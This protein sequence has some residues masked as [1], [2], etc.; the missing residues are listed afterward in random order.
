VILGMQA[1]AVEVS[2]TPPVDARAALAATMRA[3]AAAMHELGEAMRRRLEQIAAR[4]G[5]STGVDAWRGSSLAVWSHQLSQVSFC[6]KPVSPTCVGTCGGF[7][8][9][10][11]AHTCSWAHHYVTPRWIEA[12]REEL[13]T[14][15]RRISNPGDLGYRGVR[16]AVGLGHRF[17][18]YKWTLPPAPSR[19][20]SVVLV[21]RRVRRNPKP[22][23]CP[24]LLNPIQACFGIQTGRVFRPRPTLTRAGAASQ[25]RSFAA[26]HGHQSA[27]K[28]SS[29]TVSRL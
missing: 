10:C 1:P 18:V 26:T 16:G 12:V 21:I 22:C 24:V 11:P 19:G 25:L 9:R 3:T 8:W 4:V 2:L 14:R 28:A 17:T 20:G 27:A 7:G 23:C 15:Q 29:T 13:N 5:G 6:R